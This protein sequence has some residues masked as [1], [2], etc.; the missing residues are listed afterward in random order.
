MT[1]HKR[2]G[3]YIKF[4]VYLAIGV[5]VNIAGITLFF[6]MD[7]TANKVYSISDASKKVVSTLSEPLTIKVFFTKRFIALINYH[8]IRRVPKTRIQVGFFYFFFPYRNERFQFSLSWQK[9][10]DLHTPW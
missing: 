5:L 4:I 6:R 7:L 10:G 3:K 2:S 8:I 1:G 9:Q